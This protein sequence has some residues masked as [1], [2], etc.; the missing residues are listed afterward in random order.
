MMQSV[1]HC[2]AVNGNPE[3]PSVQYISGV[4]QTYQDTL[5]T[6]KLLGPTK[7]APLLEE[8]HK[9]LTSKEGSQEYHILLL[10]T[11]GAINDYRETKNVIYKLAHLP[12]SIIIV[13]V[14]NANFN[15]MKQLD[16]KYDPIRDSRGRE[17]PRD[18][19]QFVQYNKCVAEGTL[20]EEVLA[21]VPAQAVQYMQQNGI[22]P[23][24][25]EQTLPP[26]YSYNYDNLDVD[27]PPRND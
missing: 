15:D 20:N 10:L 13:G 25:L 7:F 24:E 5:E 4:M 8:F 18:V 14:G 21:E 11:D 23:A 9:M 2:F 3:N 26:A 16:A 19:V 17:A 27:A 22:V 6:I 1:S 12:C